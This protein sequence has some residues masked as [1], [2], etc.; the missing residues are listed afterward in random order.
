MK[1]FLALAALAASAPAWAQ[2]DP[3]RRDGP[4]QQLRIYRLYDASRVAFHERCGFA[5]VGHFPEVGR[6]FGRWVDVGF[7]QVML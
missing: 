7:W 6:K 1:I 2:E 4:V 3:V 5:R